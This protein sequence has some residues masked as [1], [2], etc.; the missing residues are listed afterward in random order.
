[1]HLA[2]IEIKL[3]AEI[4]DRLPEDLLKEFIDPIDLVELVSAAS[5]QIC[6]DVGRV[7]CVKSRIDC[8]LVAVQRLA[9]L[10]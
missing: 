9:I 5:Q 8:L 4:V 10:T 6:G 3:I 2:L 1:M 7:D